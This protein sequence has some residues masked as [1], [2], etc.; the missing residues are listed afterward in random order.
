MVMEFFEFISNL[1]LFSVAAEIVIF[2]FE[3]LR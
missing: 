1:M 3:D 2:F